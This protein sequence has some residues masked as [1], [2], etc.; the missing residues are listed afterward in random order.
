MVRMFQ[1]P[2][3]RLREVPFDEKVLVDSLSKEMATRQIAPST[4]E[5][6][7]YAI[8][9]ATFLS[10]E[11]RLPFLDRVLRKR[12][13]LDLGAGFTS[14]MERFSD[15]YQVSEYVAVDLYLAYPK[16]RV[17]GREYVNEDMLRYLSVQPDCSAN[18]CMNAI[19][20]EMLLHPNRLIQ[21]GYGEM[22]LR[23]ISRVVYPRGIAFG[24]QSPLLHLLEDF[25]FERIGRV[26]GRSVTS[27]G[28][29]YRKSGPWHIDM[30]E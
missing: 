24:M 6:A 22:L 17:P 30:P 19:D 26:D 2:P 29:L 11:E 23:A 28:A 1:L 25:G 8:E 7:N 16:S 13:L 27:F 18:I 15:L 4:A 3:K 20:Q 14:G 5:L 12:R 21:D 9:G 10:V